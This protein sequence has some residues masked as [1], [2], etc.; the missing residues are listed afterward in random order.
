MF[1]RFSCVI[2]DAFRE[3]MYHH[4][5]DEKKQNASTIYSNIMHA[6]DDLDKN[7]EMPVEMLK[8]M[9]EIAIGCVTQ[10]WCGSGRCSTI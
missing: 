6:L 9:H 10:Y 8:A 2:G 1:P 5:S 4:I 7:N 3:I